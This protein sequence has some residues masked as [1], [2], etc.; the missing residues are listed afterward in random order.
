[1]IRPIEQHERIHPRELPERIHRVE[2]TDDAHAR[3][4][5]IAVR[6]ADDQH[7]RNH[8]DDSPPEDTYEASEQPPQSDEK[9]LQ[10]HEK[11]QSESPDEDGGI[12]ITV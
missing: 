12:D 1:M 11:D 8:P 2:G 10:S 7:K 3:E 5:S 9:P 6:H 4:F